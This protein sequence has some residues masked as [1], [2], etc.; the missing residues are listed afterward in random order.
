MLIS[1][2]DQKQSDNRLQIVDKNN[3]NTKNVNTKN[4][5]LTIY[6]QAVQIHHRHLQA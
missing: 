6:M 2:Y 5:Q 4:V 1:T 3:V